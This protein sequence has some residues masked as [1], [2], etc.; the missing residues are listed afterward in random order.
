MN[1]NPLS[2]REKAMENQWIK[3]KEKRMAKEMAAKTQATRD[4][5][6]SSTGQQQASQEQK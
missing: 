2:D 4:A 3:E 5:G 6:S 1:P